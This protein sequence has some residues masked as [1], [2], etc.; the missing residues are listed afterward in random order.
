MSLSASTLR[1][2]GMDLRPL[3]LIEKRA[4]LEKLFNDADSRLQ[5]SHAVTGGGKAFFAAV[6]KLDLEGMVSKRPNSA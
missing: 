1:L 6:D 5:F 3:P 4:Q 2:N